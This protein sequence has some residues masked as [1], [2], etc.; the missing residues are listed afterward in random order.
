MVEN[1]VEDGKFRHILLNSFFIP[2]SYLNPFLRR[3]NYDWTICIS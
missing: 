3:G 1:F 2:F